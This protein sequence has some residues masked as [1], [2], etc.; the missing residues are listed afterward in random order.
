MQ[1]PGRGLNITACAGRPHTLT[2]RSQKRSAVGDESDFLDLHK[3]D[4]M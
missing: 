1:E 2:V 3:D 4:H